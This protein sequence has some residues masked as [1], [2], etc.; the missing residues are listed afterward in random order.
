MAREIPT[1]SFS[2]SQK[3]KMLHLVPGVLQ[4]LFVRRP[5]MVAVFTRMDSDRR[6]YRL[7]EALRRKYGSGSFLLRGGRD[8]VLTE[9]ALIREVL[10]GSPD[11]WGPP[12]PKRKGMGHFQPGALTLSTGD[13]WRR[14][15]LYNEAVLETGDLH[16][17]AGGFL[18]IVRDDTGMALAEWG[19]DVDWK[20]F[21]RLFERVAVQVIFGRGERDERRLIEALETL[22]RQSN[23]LVALRR[24]RDFAE[25]H[26][27]I[28]RHLA[29]P[30]PGSLLDAASHGEPDEAVRVGR[31]VPHWMFAMGGTLAV[32]VARAL[33]VIA[34]RRDVEAM[35]RRE[36]VGADLGDARGVAGLAYL[37]GCLQEAMRL[38]PT[39][40][41]I[42]REAQHDVELAGIEVPAGGKALIPNLFNHRDAAAV[43]AA[44]EF[45]PERW[46]GE[47][48]P[49]RFNHFSN[50]PQI[51]AGADLAMFLGVA[52]MAHLLAASR[53]TLASPALPTAGEL[54]F[55]L[56]HFDLRLR[57]AS[58]PA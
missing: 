42:A 46:Q 20:R 54:P 57:L 47:V 36:L 27:G 40:P 43:E 13:E 18:Q 33:A 7:L 35:V 44:H 32:N 1:L 45:R 8:L 48:E 11:P 56:N 10:E 39:T 15:R 9:P 58:A 3:F 50:G 24:S 25:L 17:L 23:R 5:A 53:F 21:D 4:G 12:K 16:H 51:C 31:Q 49:Y 52:A 41:L 29:E 26:G 14:R 28:E 6:G 2:E 55:M 34:A 37:S 38:W 30:H 19:G 22:M